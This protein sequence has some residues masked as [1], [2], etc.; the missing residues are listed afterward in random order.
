MWISSAVVVLFALC[1]LFLGGSARHDMVQLTVLRPVAALFLI[2]ALYWFVWRDASPLKPFLVLLGLWAL[3]MGLQVIPLP[4]SIWLLLPGREAIHELDALVLNEAPWRPI[5]LAPER[6]FNALGSIIVPMAALLIAISMRI[7][8][9]VLLLIVA[10]CGIL[11]CAFGMIQLASGGSGAFYLYRV[12][13]LG[14]LVGFLA[15][16][17]HSGVYMA[18]TLLVITKLGLDPRQSWEPPWLGAACIAAGTFMLLGILTNGS[19]AGMIIG[20]GALLAAIAMVWSGVQK[21][22]KRSRS[23]R[24]VS[25]RFVNLAFGSGVAVTV[26]LLTLFVVTDNIPGLEDAFTQDPLEDLRFRLLEALTQM[27]ATHWLVGT[28]FG[29]FAVVYFQFESTA[30][31][32]SSYVNHAHNDW[33]QLVIEGGAPALLLLGVL[34]AVIG[35]LLAAIISARGW[36][37]PSVVFWI[38]VFGVLAA[39]SVADYPLRTPIFQVVSI[40]LLC[41]LA[42]EAKE[43]RG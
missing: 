3:W 9:R 16:E 43:A 19:R 38:A 10:A 33:V 28:G 35:R 26:F 18:L 11:H 17:N 20:F 40:W 25:K 12:T 8:A 4:P 29:T 27:A 23:K 42:L 13:N 22:S 2:P 31:L 6:S 21:R 34:L 41:S 24:R 39:A 37:S 5:S 36:I 7:Q 1:V 14:G 32:M 30:L 15:N